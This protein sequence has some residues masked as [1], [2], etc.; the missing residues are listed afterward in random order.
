MKVCHWESSTRFFNSFISDWL[1]L[2]VKLYFKY[3][4]CINNHYLYL[5]NQVTGVVRSFCNIVGHILCDLKC[6]Q[7]K[8]T[9]ITNR[10]AITEHDLIQKYLITR[11]NIFST[12]IWKWPKLVSAL[13]LNLIKQHLFVN[14]IEYEHTEKLWQIL[15]FETY[16]SHQNNLV[17]S[18]SSYFSNITFIFKTLYVFS[19]NDS[20]KRV[21]Y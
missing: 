20:V 10:L 9:C 1:R 8:Q 11:T 16:L 3:I 21:S 6:N 12:A 7:R 2:K 13:K 5:F 15:P 4:F 19:P 14:E 17:H 18:S